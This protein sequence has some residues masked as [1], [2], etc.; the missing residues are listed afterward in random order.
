MTKVMVPVGLVQK[1][2]EENMW[3]IMANDYPQG[4]FVGDEEDAIAHAD[5]LSKKDFEKSF[6]G[7][8]KSFDEY[9]AVV[10]WRPRKVPA[11][12]KNIEGLIK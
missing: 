3:V 10:H 6:R 2:I 12:I 5:K 4:V 1:L 9:K 7:R 8:F 11:D